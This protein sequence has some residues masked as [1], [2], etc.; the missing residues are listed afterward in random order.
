MECLLGKIWHFYVITS[1]FSLTLLHEQNNEIRTIRATT[2]I[3]IIN[4]EKKN[5]M[6]WKMRIFRCNGPKLCSLQGRN[7]PKAMD[8]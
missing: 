7:F 1:N 8:A 3:A 5:E 2:V 4:I 6:I